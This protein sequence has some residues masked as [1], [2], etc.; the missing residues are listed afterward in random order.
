MRVLIASGGSGGHIFPA[1]SLAKELSK[2]NIEIIFVASTRRLDKKILRGSPYK[3]AFISAN[4]M[5]YRLGLGAL[6]FFVK[7]ILDIFQA[8][9]ILTRFRP[10]VAVGFGGYTAGAVMLLATRMKI[11]TV[12]HEQNVVPGRTN[13]FLGRSADRIA[14]SFPETARHF[15]NK[16]VTLT[17]NPLR[18]ESLREN[19]PAAN[20]DFG[21]DA[22]KFT[23]LVM[24]G[25]QGARSLN[26]L[27]SKGL[28][29]L[30]REEK[31]KLQ[32]IHLAGA[33]DS[34][35]LK[36]FYSRSGIAGRVFGFIE[37]INE[38]YS[39]CDLVVSR[40][41]AAAIFELAAFA[42][43]MVLIPYPGRKN[44]QR[45][46]AMFLAEKKAAV[47]RD[48]NG[49]KEEEFKDLITDLM[50]DPAKRKGLSENAKKLCVRDSAKKLAELVQGLS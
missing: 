29:R 5:P 50:N 43:P 37:N 15:K 46:N 38:A 4:P 9:Y 24:G 7:L 36:D 6:V 32:V 26:D 11:K 44:N 42:K 27:V 28:T 31:E 21:L 10:D 12:I 13:T 35:R 18:E 47:Y 40:A 30:G 8:L 1:V 48:E 33:R 39:A 17:G 34:G 25:S 14:T 23:I 19:R 2:S 22:G 20:D 45:F 3:T 49:L 41:G 16:N